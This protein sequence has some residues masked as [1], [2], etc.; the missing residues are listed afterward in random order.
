MATFEDGPTFDRIQP[1][2]WCG[3]NGDGKVFFDTVGIDYPSVVQ[4][5]PT[6]V[7]AGDR[8]N[9]NVTA[10]LDLGLKPGKYPMLEGCG[11]RRPCQ[12]AGRTFLDRE[13][14]LPTAWM[15]DP[16]PR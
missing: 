13:L 10:P 6:D 2:G 8:E 15:D 3:G 14:H 11:A 16:A 1:G 9:L 4:P 5:E 12:P 7:P